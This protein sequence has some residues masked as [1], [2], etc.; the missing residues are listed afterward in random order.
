MEEIKRQGKIHLLF[1]TLFGLASVGLIVYYLSNTIIH[2][3]TP[4]Q[5]PINSLER[6]PLTWL[7]FPAE[8]FSALFGLYF[9]Y[10]LWS[11]RFRM[12][13]PE[14]LKNKKNIPVGILIPAYRE[15]VE[16]LR[17]TVEHAKK[18]RW[19][20]KVQ[21]YLLME[22]SPGPEY[23]NS[24]EALGRKHDVTVHWRKDNEGK[25][26]GNIN[27]AVKHVVR[28]D[29][30]V[31][32]D[33]DQ[34]PEPEFL[35]VTMDHF[36]DPRVSFVQTPQYLV[37]ETTPLERAAKIGANIFFQAMCVARS[38][39]HAM[40][41]CGTNAVFSRQAYEKVGGFSYY[42][43]TEDI[44]LG[45]KM[46]QEGY[47]G[48]YVP[49]IVCKGFAPPDFPSYASQQYRWSNGNLAILRESWMKIFGGRFSFRQQMHAVFA[50]GWWLIGIVTLIYIVTP[51]IALLFGLAT[52]HTW[53]PTS[54]LMLLY[55]HVTMG[56]GMIYVGL[57]GR[58]DSDRVTFKDALLQYSLITN[59]AFIYAKAAINALFKRY[60][61]FVTTNKAGSDSGYRHILPNL[62]LGGLCFAVSIYA[63]YNAAIASTF[64]QLR[65]FLPI[66]LWLLFYAV[67]LSSS[68]LFV[69]T[70]GLS[71][72]EMIK[73]A[74]R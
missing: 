68:V 74:R 29:Y 65:T 34:A 58:L 62:L 66:S 23:T 20:G 53:L 35:E 33:A 1:Y 36:S 7:I 17:R 41:F 40:V 3:T 73:E 11:D 25:K 69:G 60:V 72:E 50:L 63:V 70:K 67:V 71:P 39:D 57:H 14:P 16:I 22:P 37:N 15:P 59:S 12:P 24:I 2:F 47:F 51:L 55:V 4:Q 6:M 21:V 8:I 49:K 48:V 56:I 32:L 38:N 42:T 46:D 18:V 43:A 19:P 31:V 64:E 30:F 13:D 28:E 44:E 10:T 9:V 52:H 54:L 5:F 45:L 27:N 61:G 26:A